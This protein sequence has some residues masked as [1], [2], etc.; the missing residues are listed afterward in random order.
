MQCSIAMRT[1][2]AVISP[3][4]KILRYLLQPNLC[5]TMRAYGLVVA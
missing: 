2:N 3:F 4:Q 1:L 5:I